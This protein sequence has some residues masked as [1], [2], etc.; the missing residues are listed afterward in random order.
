[1]VSFMCGGLIVKPASWPLKKHLWAFLLLFKNIFFF[2]PSVLNSHHYF[3]FEPVLL[4]VQKWALF[5]WSPRAGCWPSLCKGT[6]E[7]NSTWRCAETHLHRHGNSVTIMDAMITLDNG[8]SRIRND[9]ANF[10][11]WNVL[12][13]VLLSSNNPSMVHRWLQSVAGAFIVVLQWWNC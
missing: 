9:Q 3:S 13:F 5:K 4:W 12:R 8:D 7:R 1:M 2:A 6:E 11:L 10:G